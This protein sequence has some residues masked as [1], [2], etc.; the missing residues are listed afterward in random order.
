VRAASGAV[1]GAPRGRRGG[2]LILFE[3][4]VIGAGLLAGGWIARTMRSRANARGRA[5]AG[6]NTGRDPGRDDAARF[7]GFP[8]KWGDVVVRVAERDE[9]W[10]AG[11]LL[12]EEERPVAALFIAPEAGADRAIWARK[13]EGAMAWLAPAPAGAVT[14][15]GEPLHAL[16]V[17]GARYERSLRLPVRVTRLGSGAPEVGAQAIV[18]EYRG[19]GGARLLVVAGAERTLAWKGAAL[20]A[21]EYDV[22]PGD[23]AGQE[24]PPSGDDR[25]ADDEA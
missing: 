10:L 21:G 19:A 16:E 13:G 24:A 9:A 14:A 25:S 2:S 6:K 23:G 8:C 22:L 5:R 12:F 18:A 4:L 1:G 20:L 7:D 11:A 3:A 17:E 15:V